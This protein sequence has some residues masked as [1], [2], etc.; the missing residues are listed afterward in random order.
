MNRVVWAVVAALAV[1]SLF[2]LAP[3]VYS[4]Y[5]IVSCGGPP[6]PSGPAPGCKDTLASAYD[7]PSC[8]LLRIGVAGDNFTS[9]Y[10]G[11]TAPGAWSYYLG[12]AP[13]KT[14][15]FSFY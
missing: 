1:A 5:H 11:T 12:C 8:L 13:D 9:G 14:L 7:S 4:P 10:H 2:F 6:P 3:I 15:Y